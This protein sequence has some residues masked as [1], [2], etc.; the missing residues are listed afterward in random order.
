MTLSRG[1]VRQTACHRA[2]TKYAVMVQP[3]LFGYT[4]LP[5]IAILPCNAHAVV[6]ERHKATCCDHATILMCA[7]NV[8]PNAVCPCSCTLLWMV[9]NMPHHAALTL[10]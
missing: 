9:T 2:V 3:L 5:P 6:Q 4:V 1:V 10:G 7:P 8:W